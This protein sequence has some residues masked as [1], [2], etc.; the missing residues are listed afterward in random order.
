MALEI[1]IKGE[2]AQIIELVDE[3]LALGIMLA[4]AADDDEPSD[5]GVDDPYGLPGD[6]TPWAAPEPEEEAKPADCQSA[7]NAVQSDQDRIA[8]LIQI[9]KEIA[10]R[11]AEIK[12][13]KRELFEAGIK[14]LFAKHTDLHQIHWR[15]S[16]P[17]WNDGEP[18]R[19]SVGSIF[20]NNWDIEYGGWDDDLE[21]EYE[22]EEDEED[23]EETLSQTPQTNPAQS[24]EAFYTHY[25]NLY[26]YGDVYDSER[27]KRFKEVMSALPP[28][29][30][31]KAF[32]DLFD[33]SDYEDMY[34]DGVRVTINREGV[35]IEDYCEN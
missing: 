7:A 10:E 22:D 2:P 15:Q 16:T 32:L 5:S 26:G 6:Y 13:Q 3:L 30:E 17:S 20:V 28:I 4:Q 35:E 25:E 33:E 34:G 19:F 31:A 27:Y 14:D 12:P 24:L 1:T 29:A 21:E 11:I 18:C 23:S 9:K 8:R